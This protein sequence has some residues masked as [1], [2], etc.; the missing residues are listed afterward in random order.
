M[1]Q[2]CKFV[3]KKQLNFNREQLTASVLFYLLKIYLNMKYYTFLLTRYFAAQL[4]MRF[5]QYNFLE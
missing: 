3:V 2:I 5:S 1:T 4:I